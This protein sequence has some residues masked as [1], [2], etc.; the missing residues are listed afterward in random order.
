MTVIRDIQKQALDKLEASKV[1]LE[2]ARNIIEASQLHNYH[3][4]VRIALDHIL[5]GIALLSVEC[6]RIEGRLA[7]AD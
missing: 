7:D 1:Q 4:G 2:T 3:G 6:S 5:S